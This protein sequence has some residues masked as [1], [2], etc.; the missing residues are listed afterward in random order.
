[1]KKKP[2]FLIVLMFVIVAIAIFVVREQSRRGA[3]SEL[4]QVMRNYQKTF[5]LDTSP[6]IFP[7]GRSTNLSGKTNAPNP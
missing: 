5:K 4:P 3:E 6:S 1:M 7:D 2:A